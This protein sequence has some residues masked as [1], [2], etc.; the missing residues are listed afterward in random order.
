[1]KTIIA[2]FTELKNNV[3]AAESEFEDLDY[4]K[5]D[6][7]LKSVGISLKDS[8]GQF[9]NLDDVFLE[10]SQ[11]WDTL[12]R[13]TQR[14]IATTAAGS[15]Q[16]SRFLAMM[17][18]YDRTLELIE[19]AQDSAGRSS[20]Q[21]AKYQDTIESKIKKLK[22]SWEQLRVGMLNP[23]N[24]KGIIEAVTKIVEKLNKMDI[25][26][27]ASIGVVFAT[28]GKKLVTN[29]IS[30]IQGSATR[31]SEA[32]S[33]PVEQGS[34]RITE[35]VVDGLN[36]TTKNLRRIYPELNNELIQTLG[37]TNETVSADLLAKLNNLST[38][39]QS[40]A[41][42]YMEGAKSLKMQDDKLTQMV[43]KLHEQGVSEEVI[44]NLMSDQ[45]TELGQQAA[46]YE[47]MEKQ[48]EMRRRNLAQ[49]GLTENQLD[50]LQ[51]SGVNI[52][53]TSDQL[54]SIFAG[55]GGEI[56]S[57]L[58]GLLTTSISSA[59]VSS[60]TTIA[61]GGSVEDAIKNTGK[62]LLITALPQAISSA[63]GILVP[64]LITV[65]T[66]TVLGPV[67]AVLGAAIGTYLLARYIQDNGDLK[68]AEKIAQQA[69]EKF[70]KA[71]E[72]YTI[73]KQMTDEDEKNLKEQNERVDNL[74]EEINKYQELNKIHNK[75]AEEQEE[76]NELIKN[77]QNELPE[78]KNFYDERNNQLTISNAKLDEML[79]KEKEIA[80]Q[81]TA[82][83]YA[84]QVSEIQAE[85][86]VLRAEDIANYTERDKEREQRIKDLKDEE[87]YR[88]SE[89]ARAH[90][91]GGKANPHLD[92]EIED[93][94]NDY[95]TK[96]LE[97]INNE[98]EEEDKKIREA[99]YNNL[100]ESAEKLKKVINEAIDKEFP[101]YNETYRN[102][103]H[104]N[105]GDI[106]TYEEDGKAK[107]E[108]LLGDIQLNSSMDFSTLPLAL[109]NEIEALY[110]SR[111]AAIEYFNQLKE[112]A[113]DDEITSTLIN[114]L[115]IKEASVMAKNAAEK[116]DEQVG[117]EL[118]ERF[119]KDIE[120]FMLLTPT[121]FETAVREANWGILNKEKKK[122]QDE[123]DQTR[124]E[125]L[126]Q[127]GI[128]FLT[129]GY[130]YSEKNGGTLE[131]TRKIFDEEKLKQ[132]TNDELISL[133]NF[134]EDKI[135]ELGR[136]TAE[137][138]LNELSNI[139]GNFDIDIKDQVQI[140]NFLDWENVD[141]SNLEEYKKK[142]TDFY[143]ET[144]NEGRNS[145]E[146]RSAA[147]SMFDSMAEAAEDNKLYNAMV[148]SWDEAV[149]KI[150]KKY[151][152]VS[153][154]GGIFKSVLAGEETLID[155]SDLDSFKEM[156]KEMQE[157]G[158]LSKDIKM[159]DLFTW[160]SEKGKY[161][162]N[163]KEVKKV[164]KS[165]KTDE[166]QNLA[167]IA[168]KDLEAQAEKTGK[169]FTGTKNALTRLSAGTD[170]KPEEW[171]TI[172][173]YSKE[174]G[175]NIYEN[176]KQTQA[177]NQSLNNLLDDTADK[178][179]KLKFSIKESAS[180]V[181]TF[182]SAALEQV[183]DKKVS[184]S[185]YSSIADDIAKMNEQYKDLNMNVNN[186]ID[187]MG[188]F[189]WTKYE[190]DLTNYILKLQKEG[191][192]AG[193]LVQ[194]LRELKE[195][196]QEVIDK[197]KELEENARKEAEEAAK[198][199]QEERQKLIDE[200][201]K[202]KE[203]AE[204]AVE[205]ATNDVTKAEEDL[206][207]AQ[208]DL[209]NAQKAVADAY[210]E[211]AEKE[212]AVL[213]VQKELNEAMY[214]TGN[215]RKSTL[216]GLYN[217]DQLLKQINNDISDLKDNLSDYSS[218]MDAST[219][220]MQYGQLMHNKKVTLMSQQVAYQSN[221]SAAKSVLGEYSAYYTEINGRLL[222]DVAKLNAAAM[223]DKIK[224]Q[225]ESTVQTYN[226]SVD[227]IHDISNQIKQI[228]K[229]FRDFQ[230]TYRDKY[231]NLQEKVIETL[232]NQA[233]EE[234]NIEKEKYA[235][236]EEADNEYVDA[237]EA[238]IAKQRELRQQENDE[239]DLA[240][241][242][243]KLSLLQRDTSGANQKDILKQQQDVE[244]T[245]Q[246]LND[247]KIDSIVKSLRELYKEQKKSRDAEIKY[248][249]TVLQNATFIEEANAVISS[250]QTADDLVSWFYE[251][252]QE[253]QNMTNEQLEQYTETLEQMYYDREIYMNTSMQDF[254]EMLNVSQEE[255]N[256]MTSSVTQNLTNETEQAFARVRNEVNKTIQ[257]LEKKLQDA[258][259]AVDDAKQKLSDALDTVATNVTKVQ[260]ATDALAEARRKLTDQT[261]ALAAATEKLT[262]AQAANLDEVTSSSSNS[263]GGGSSSGGSS[264]GNPN[265]N[266]PTSTTPY[267]DS[268]SS[269][270]KARFNAAIKNIDNTLTQYWW[271]GAD[272]RPD[273]M[274]K[275]GKALKE[276]YGSAVQGEGQN[277]GNIYYAKNSSI[278]E[279][280]IAHGEIKDSIYTYH[281]FAKG[282][283][284]N[285]TG[286]AWVDGTPAQPEAFLSVEDTRN[287]AHFTD[288]LS[289]L[290]N[291]FGQFNPSVSSTRETVINVTVNIDG[292]SSDYDVDQAVERVKQNII[293]AAHQIGSTVILHQ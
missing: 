169:A 52:T 155:Q 38:E 11:K 252:S 183:N 105:E 284:V 100:K 167:K 196:H 138:Y 255:I 152:S 109:R 267:Y 186:Y 15:R 157:L 166:T 102:I 190:A 241:K 126:T 133:N 170:L 290:Y 130:K 134:A 82:L 188:Q 27:I 210:E 67:T 81:K 240:Q 198:K 260:E 2:R 273:D 78:L 112:F 116:F 119:Q 79:N 71:K 176:L 162:A 239:N 206:K 200:A 89:Y 123:Y 233:Q 219:G 203:D 270:D 256:G 245:R 175:T 293:D 189:N 164:W 242:E 34:R 204:K 103:L 106:S 56:Q 68:A 201:Q 262:T 90:D 36:V 142:F 114:D 193:F 249:E 108:N 161:L 182:K 91:N 69:E 259:Q 72:K 57:A 40:L 31:I 41:L 58:T 94:W 75:T 174:T 195:A 237:L 232:R 21:F 5:V 269:A 120:E 121:E 95:Y 128:G 51:Q 80:R 125:L 214:G 124:A 271:A 61:S 178:L 180:L 115:G 172:K 19:T 10:L 277:T 286:P 39:A 234:L 253:T 276:K 208:E 185:T 8:M 187:T 221:L 168:L 84:D 281:R 149:E 33:A 225:I 158:F 287:I 159:D 3:S 29:L 205:D 20:E 101:D 24:Y 66:T 63:A 163:I 274:D 165:L 173:N 127:S 4:N 49:Q 288:V 216:D 156:I 92:Q 226:D 268:L 227:K 141:A 212:K 26:Q 70:E 43:R 117:D 199:L 59:L 292:V 136:N 215:T 97:I 209:T 179:E 65:F 30:S 96:Q 53:T 147:E 265:N 207:K 224:D 285:Y 104:R 99:Y 283:L 238:A 191:K 222:V 272:N 266:P 194:V 251:H 64:K 135:K 23:N 118:R 148:K 280:K 45:T 1:M 122:I 14:Y 132:L 275:F 6:T 9:R 247:K 143:I 231:I 98:F 278:L 17:E 107:I 236:M 282:G 140:M 131:K 46:L 62:T 257:D 74:S 150:Q 18:N 73:I 235:A 243:K 37:K 55:T 228:D 76:Y 289:S 144:I 44:R 244:N 197:Q 279:N 202:N 254:T 250:W 47:Q 146:A 264:G 258:Q 7:A 50:T 229:E 213:E 111:D 291:S 42:E 60:L 153:K 154:Q 35:L 263:S 13:N 77:L 248:R 139:M 171:E 87:K 218:G 177:W 211:I 184:T 48:Q 192:D 28:V 12:D 261:N 32:I 230:K 137:K 220:V 151:E 160:D 88:R 54:R 22:T 145:P 85:R 83:Y 223:P 217:Y 181:S 129:N 86:N 93:Y 110:G 25:K 246:N 113:S 16:Q